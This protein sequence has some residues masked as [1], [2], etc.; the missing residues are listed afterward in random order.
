MSETIPLYRRQTILEHAVGAAPV[1]QTRRRAGGHRYQPGD[2]SFSQLPLAN[3]PQITVV[4]GYRARRFR[5]AGLQAVSNAPIGTLS[6]TRR[7]RA[8]PGR[9][10][11][12]L[13][14]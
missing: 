9:S 1:A 12:L 5:P 8:C 4:D 7:V 14:L 3:R 10:A 2:E 13:Q 11:R 6:M